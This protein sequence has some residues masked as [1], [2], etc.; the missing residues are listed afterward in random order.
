MIASLQETVR[1]QQAEIDRISIN[2][3]SQIDARDAENAALRSQLNA[4]GKDFSVLA[5]AIADMMTNAKRLAAVGA[6]ALNIVNRDA[7][8]DRIVTQLRGHPQRPAQ[9]E[10]TD[11]VAGDPYAPRQRM[12]AR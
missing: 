9:H 5:R 2:S 8:G 6:H 1:M 11:R 4:K 12:A 7:V 3:Q 10:A